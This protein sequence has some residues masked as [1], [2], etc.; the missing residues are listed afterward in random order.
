MRLT[1]YSDYSLR[2]LIHVAL[3][4]DVSTIREIAT[5]YD[6]SENHLMKVAHRLGQLGYLRTVR[7][8]NGGLL[9]ARPPEHINI[10]EVVRQTEDD[11][12]LVECFGAG[13]RCMITPA[14]TLKHVLA[15]ALAAFMAVL[16]R[17]TLA[18]LVRPA[19]RLAALLG[20]PEMETARPV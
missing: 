1:R 8:R 10:G 13:D 20:L 18:D 14:C 11:M 6:I 4:R 7:G 16:D 17:H 3:K 19:D 12:A 5:R 2:I 15:D 9:L